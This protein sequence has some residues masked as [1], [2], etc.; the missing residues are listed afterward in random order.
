VVADHAR[1]AGTHRYVIGKG[2]HIQ[3]SLVGPDVPLHLQQ[4]ADGLIE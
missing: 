2:N 4:I 1:A 3:H